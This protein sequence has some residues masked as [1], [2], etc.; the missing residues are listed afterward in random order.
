MP[1]WA[2]SPKRMAASVSATAPTTAPAAT[3][4]R[5]IRSRT[6]RSSSTIRTTGAPPASLQKRRDG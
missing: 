4:T 5:T 6:W 3:S 2:V 1:N